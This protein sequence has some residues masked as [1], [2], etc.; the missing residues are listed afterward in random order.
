MGV[1][2]GQGGSQVA[3]C[4]EWQLDS[5]TFPESTK[6]LLF[7]LRRPET[8]GAPPVSGS[9]IRSSTVYTSPSLLFH[10]PLFTPSHPLCLC[11]QPV[12][13]AVPGLRP[14]RLARRAGDARSGRRVPPALLHLQRLFLPPADR[15]PLRPQGRAATVCQG[16]L[17][18]VS[19]QPDLLRHW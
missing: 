16:G 11:P 2:G 10:Q 4:S 15:R 12:C 8:R 13:S 3:G 9:Q 6:H 17:P 14:G 19:G 1:V 18:P 7:G 5:A